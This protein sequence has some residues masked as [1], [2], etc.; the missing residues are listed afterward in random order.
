VDA[1]GRLVQVIEPLPVTFEGLLRFRAPDSIPPQPAIFFRRWLFELLGPLDDQLHYG[2]DY[3]FWLRVAARYQFRY[4]DQVMATYR[5][6]ST[7]KSGRGFE[8]FVPEWRLICERH[9]R[10]R[11]WRARLAWRRDQIIHGITKQLVKCVSPLVPRRARRWG[12]RLWRRI[13]G[14]RRR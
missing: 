12:G 11:G 4:V 2:M 10:G 7:S 6:H 1:E 14:E 5:L 8:A 13:L 9:L 3:D